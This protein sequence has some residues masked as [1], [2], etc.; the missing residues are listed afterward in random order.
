MLSQVS[1]ASDNELVLR[2]DPASWP[3][4]VRRHFAAAGTRHRTFRA[5]LG[6]PADRPIVMGGHH[7]IFWHPGILSKYLA[8]HALAK[9][10]GGSSAW[11]VVDQDTDDPF[12]IR[13][14]VRAGN[15]R[16]AV[17]TTRP[18]SG[19]LSAVP[20]VPVAYRRPAL[21]EPAPASDP[22]TESVRDGLARIADALRGHSQAPSA[23][24]QVAAAL[25]DL[26]KP[27]VPPAQS[28][29]ATGLSTTDLFADLLSR[30]QADPR[31]C[32]R[33]YNGAVAGHPDAALRKLAFDEVNER[34]ELPLWR[35]EPGKPRRR[36]FAD[37]LPTIPREHLSPKALLMTAMLR[38]GACDLFIH[39]TGGE[40]YDRATKDWLSSWAP[41]LELCPGAVATATLHLPL[42]DHRPPAPAQVA[43]A[44]WLAHRARH[45]PAILND[46]P[47]ATHKRDLAAKIAAQPRHSAERAVL[48]RRMH[49]GLGRAREAH[50]ADLE[51]LGRDA[52]RLAEQSL[53]ATVASDRTWA[54]PLYPEA[55]LLALRARIDVAC[56]IGE[57]R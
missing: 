9:S 42:L 45:D 41:D 30:F 11:I 12:L 29:L 18:V 31:A 38:A 26:L 56:A 2:P 43:R 40:L 33:A 7:A 50:A 44:R 48:Y 17:V 55:M 14:P 13:Y 22:A 49:E 57:P 21:I 34:Y 35:L 15:G 46:E 36:V 6:L 8:G 39:G 25:E 51:R 32:I 1:E 19:A 16:L 5:Q 3:T 54:F 52:A 37:D 4:L 47:A 20:D 23:G 10:V 27:L 28:I 24:R 53:D